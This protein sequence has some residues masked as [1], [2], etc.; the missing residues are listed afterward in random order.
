VLAS[1]LGDVQV[2]GVFDGPDDG[3]P[4][5]L[6]GHD[7]KR[8]EDARRLLDDV[9]APVPALAGEFRAMVIASRTRPA[10]ASTRATAR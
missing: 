2:A 5:E 9:V 7:K 3:S 1:A 4:V 10:P 6:T 8:A